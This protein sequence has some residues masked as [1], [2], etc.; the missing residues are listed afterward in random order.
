MSFVQSA[1]CSL[2]LK[3]LESLLERVSTA[4]HERRVARWCISNPDKYLILEI[5]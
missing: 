4:T 1:L 2:C 5:D 3:S